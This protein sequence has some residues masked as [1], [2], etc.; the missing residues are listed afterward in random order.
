MRSP[1]RSS[2]RSQV[3]RLRPRLPVLRA[4]ANDASGSG[5]VNPVTGPLDREGAVHPFERARRIPAGAAS[6]QQGR[7][8]G[9]Q[10]RVV[11]G[12]AGIADDETNPIESFLSFGIGGNSPLAGRETDT[13]GVGWY[14]SGTSDEVG[15]ILQTVLGPIGD[16]QGVE[17][18]YTIEVA[19]WFRLTP[20]LQILDPARRSVDT[21]YLIGLRGQII[22]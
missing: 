15:P 8:S 13:F 12:R 1:A 22:L 4:A 10:T 14:R 5:Y 16:G 7:P 3:V 20:D 6:K 21:A 11:F 18:F 17:L 19:P 2:I 9:A